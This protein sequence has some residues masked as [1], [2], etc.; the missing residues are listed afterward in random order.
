MAYCHK[1]DGTWRFVLENE[2]ILYEFGPR[3]VPRQF[4]H[5]PTHQRRMLEMGAAVPRKMAAFLPVQLPPVLPS[6]PVVAH[7]DAAVHGR[8]GAGEEKGEEAESVEGAGAGAG[9][10]AVVHNELDAAFVRR[11]KVR[12]EEAVE[13]QAKREKQKIAVNASKRRAAAF[14]K[15]SGA[16]AVSGNTEALGDAAAQAAS[17]AR[18]PDATASPSHLIVCALCRVRP[19]VPTSLPACIGYLTA[20]AGESCTR[21]NVTAGVYTLLHK[22]RSFKISDDD[23]NWF[24]KVRLGCWLGLLRACIFNF[25]FTDVAKAL[26]NIRDSVRYNGLKNDL[27]KK[28]FDAVIQKALEKVNA[29]GDSVGSIDPGTG[30]HELSGAVGEE[31]GGDAAPAPGSCRS[32]LNVLQA[33]PQLAAAPPAP[34]LAARRSSR[35]T[36]AARSSGAFLNIGTSFTV[37]GRKPAQHS[38]QPQQGKS[39]RKK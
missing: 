23:G 18:P 29:G 19:R 16:A 31:A 34:E 21:C 22:Y 14:L 38:A 1:R 28:D 33:P 25:R 5:K 10:T 6:A 20:Q 3:R 7:A 13:K 26:R 32:L 36:V 27:G 11:Q 9:A 8:E 12:V 37:S 15:S 30:K 17:A 2:S 39:K 24:T 35:D 4:D